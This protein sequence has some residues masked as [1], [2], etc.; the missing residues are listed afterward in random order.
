MSTANT[1]CLDC[2]S[3]II[4]VEDHP[5]HR[6]SSTSTKPREATLLDVRLANAL[7]D[8]RELAEQL[9]ACRQAATPETALALYVELYYTRHIEL[10]LAALIESRR[11]TEVE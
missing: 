4:R 2:D 5:G 10:R 8:A 1:Y 7:R 6:L 11:P 9:I 3:R